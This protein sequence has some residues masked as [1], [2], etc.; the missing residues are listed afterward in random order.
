MKIN[1]ELKETQE[2]YKKEVE[3]LQGK[4]DHAGKVISTL[5]NHNDDP[6]VKLSGKLPSK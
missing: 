1:K 6:P 4:L 5:Q 3:E 2:K